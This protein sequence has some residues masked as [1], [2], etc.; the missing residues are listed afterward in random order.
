MRADRLVAILLL[1]QQRGQ[2]TAAEV[3]DELEISE[4]TARPRPR[5]A[6]RGRASRCTRSRAA[7][8][9]GGW[10]AAGAPTSA[11]SVPPR[12]GRC[13]SSPGRRRRRRPSCGR[14]C[15]SSCG[16][17][18]N[19]C[20][21]R[22]RPR[23]RRSTSTRRTWDQAAGERRPPPTHLDALQHAVVAGRQVVARLRRPRW[24]PVVARRRP[25]RH[26]RQGQRLVPRR[27]HRRRAAHVP[28]RPGHRGEVLATPVERPADFDLAAAWRSV[29]D[30]VQQQRTPVRADVSVRP[31]ALDRV[32]VGVGRRASRSGR[33]APTGESRPRSAA[34]ASTRWPARS[35]GLGAL[36]RGPRPGRG[37]AAAGPAGRRAHRALHAVTGAGP[38]PD[39][40]PPARRD[41]TASWGRL[42]PDLDR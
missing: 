15:A 39:R 37:A 31:E 27:R 23:R 26:R 6:G 5:G 41:V 12:H 20:A 3:A 30:D 22:P 33:P 42:S 34:T 14:R 17:C 40:R 28:D 18:P 29:T 24:R 19:R 35:R 36:D 32:P 9:A 11:G 8:A 38:L 4:R 7:T 16:R 1:L 21:P 2:V 10:P 13:S 25:A